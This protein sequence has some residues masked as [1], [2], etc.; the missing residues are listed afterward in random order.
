MKLK[1]DVK[2]ILDILSSGMFISKSSPLVHSLPIVFTK[3]AVLVQSHYKVRIASVLKVKKDYFV[4]Y[5]AKEERVGI[6][7][8][9]YKKLSSWGFT[10]EIKLS[11][12]GDTI[13]VDGTARHDSLAGD[14]VSDKPFPLAFKES[15]IGDIPEK[16]EK[17]ESY[18]MAE[19]KDLLLP[20]AS[21]Y[22][23]EF[24]D[25]KLTGRI[26]GFTQ[27]MPVEGKGKDITIKVPAEFY[28][29]ILSNLSGK[30]VVI[31][32]ELMMVFK[33]SGQFE[34]TFVLATK[35]KKND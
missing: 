5:E 7:E 2:K 13:T 25:Q 27:E 10:G 31:L 4:E 1:V 35:K 14:I 16:I 34:K 23:F 12:E 6:P 24:K 33:Q 20:K 30:V 18:F 3:D 22:V 11:L 32:H 19:A 17:I 8:E 28:N 15:E 26:G 21:E 29:V 9:L